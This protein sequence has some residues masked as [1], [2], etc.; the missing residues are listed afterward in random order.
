MAASLEIGQPAA[1][2]FTSDGNSYTSGISAISIYAAASVAFDHNGDLWVADYGNNRVLE[3]VPP[4]SNGMAA[5]LVLGQVDFTHGLSN[6]GGSPAANTL[7][8]PSGLEF[9]SGG[10]LIVEDTQNNRTLIFSAPFTNNVSA[11]T[12]LGQSNL[13][14]NFPNQL[15]NIPVGANILRTPANGLVF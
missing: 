8:F 9:D 1:T 12:V 6:Q 2:A 11:T 13:T 3:F 10:N 4:F 7:S 15:N 14:N 5:S